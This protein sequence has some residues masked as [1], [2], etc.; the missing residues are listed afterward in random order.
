MTLPEV[1]LENLTKRFS[2]V[3]AVDHITLRIRSGELLT[4]LGPS[5]CGK[6]TTLRLIAG[7]LK[8]DEGDV[9]FDNEV[10]THLPPEKRGVGMVFQNY[11]LWPHMTVYD[12]IAFG[13]KIRKLPRD[14]IRR[15]VK[16]VLEL[17]KLSGLENRY[18]RQLSGGQ[19]QRVALARA[20]V[21]EPKVLLLDEPLSNLDAKLREEMRFEIRDLQRR[22][23][24][25]TIYV[26][27]D[28]AEAM[29][30][31]DRIAIMNHGKIVQIGPPK[32]IYECPKDRFVA[33]FIGIANFI[34]GVVADVDK[35][36]GK[37]V[38]VTED[39]S[40]LTTYSRNVRKGQKVDVM[41]RPEY[42]SLAKVHTAGRDRQ[43]N[44]LLGKVIKRAYLGNV[45]DYRI[46]VGDVII[47]VQTSPEKV[48]EIGE[49][50]ELR[51]NP[52]KM[53]IISE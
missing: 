53:I 41:I 50:V 26:T 44:T 37:V 11:A 9:Y 34:K 31:A 20:L 17:V 47:R 30:L 24:I 19:Q 25:T 16:E 4:L 21:I 43:P 18:P 36:S 48:Y 38:I 8:P 13:L 28:Q 14:E 27:H 29:A 45:V 46:Q 39:N 23:K 52:N 3:V 7:L 49:T 6:T 51:L 35:D 22:L 5:G 15:K 42:I 10:V 2:D 12:N 40:I 33:S 1:Y 32:E